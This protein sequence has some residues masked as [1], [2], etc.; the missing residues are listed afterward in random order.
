[1]GTK[2]GSA[3]TSK[4]KN[5]LIINIIVSFGAV[6]AAL[7][8]LEIGLHWLIRPD[9]TRYSAVTGWRGRANEFKLL[10]TDGYE[11]PFQ[12]NSLGMHDTEHPLAKPPNTY[13]ILMLGDS[14]TEARQVTEPQTSHQ[15]LED[16]LNASSQGEQYSVISAGVPA[17]G[18]GQQLLY[19]QSEG[20]LFQPDLVLLMFYIG[21]DL[22]DNI[23]VHSVTFDDVAYY[24]PYFP[25]CDGRLDTQPWVYAPGLKPAVSTCSPFQKILAENL[26]R[27][28]LNS[29]IYMLLSPL[30][31]RWQSYHFNKDL[32]NIHMYVPLDNETFRQQFPREN[33]TIAYAWDV[34]FETIKRLQQEVEADDAELAV[35]L[36]D[37]A[38]VIDLMALSPTEQEARRQ[39]M[40]YLAM[41]QPDLPE[42]KFRRAM[43]GHQLDILNLQPELVS[44]INQNNEPLYFPHDK[45]WNILGNRVVAG[46]LHDWLQNKLTVEP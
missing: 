34:T 37:S 4:P 35:V 19:Y 39:A 46:I 23:P 20:R 2:I 6:I 22:N 31:N 7:L 33:E 28:Y 38:D 43:A 18:T 40:P 44:Y 17:W 21:N 36:I 30:F 42:A 13:R 24:S 15:I 5:Y 8:V 27:L 29:R 45:H 1:M 25:L 10:D 11:H 16:L 32:P 14:F 12:L 3:S 41:T 26:H 9:T